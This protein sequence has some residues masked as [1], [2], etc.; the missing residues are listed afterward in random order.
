[1]ISY[2]TEDHLGSPRLITDNT[3]TVISRRDFYPYG[4]QISGLGGRSQIPSYNLNH[5]LKQKFTGYERDDETGLD[6]AQARYYAFNLG[7]FTSPDPLAGKATNPQQLNR[8]TYV[9][10]NPLRFTDPTGLIAADR[11]T[12]KQNQKGLED[13]FNALLDFFFGDFYQPQGDAGSLF[14]QLKQG[15]RYKL[16]TLVN[17]PTVGASVEVAVADTNLA[18]AILKGVSKEALR[19]PNTIRLIVTQTVLMELQSVGG[20]TEDELI[21]AL[22]SR[23]IDV[24]TVKKEKLVPAV[25]EIM[26]VTLAKTGALKFTLAGESRIRAQ[27]NDIQI[28]A[29][30]KAIGLPIYTANVNDF[31]INIGGEALSTRV[32]VEVRGTKSA[33]ATKALP[34]LTEAVKQLAKKFIK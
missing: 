6:F 13:G 16:A 3:G 28:L 10:N 33:P 34:K 18:Q 21:A 1:Q 5:S 14:N 27:L 4:E 22:L 30:A 25:N 11:P 31:N 7:R 24:A 26:N 8:Y 20:F 15:F 2:L 12:N 29:E 17:P 19:V 32:K 9:L 23:G